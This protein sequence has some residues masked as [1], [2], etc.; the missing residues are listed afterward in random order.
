MR[1]PVEIFRK[2]WKCCVCF[3]EIGGTCWRIWQSLRT[4][5]KFRNV[6]ENQWIWEHAPK[7]RNINGKCDKLSKTF[8]NS[9]KY[10]SIPQKFGKFSRIREHLKEEYQNS[11]N[12]W[13][14]D[15]FFENAQNYW[16]LNWKCEKLSLDNLEKVW[17][18]HLLG[19]SWIIWQNS[20][21]TVKF[22]S[23]SE[24]QGI[25]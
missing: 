7:F 17:A 19:R 24:D 1:E 4:K 14:T 23:L 11:R 8:R 25:L 18:F 3:P 13:K 20:R 21:N 5:M 6:L 16:K 9:G 2:Y 10:P 22:R 12:C 15:L